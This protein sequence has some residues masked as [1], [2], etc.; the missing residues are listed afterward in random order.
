MDDITSLHKLIKDRKLNVC[1]YCRIS[2]DK[3]EA[4]TN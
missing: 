4:E 3:D 1:T 2:N